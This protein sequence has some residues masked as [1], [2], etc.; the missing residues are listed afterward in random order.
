[1]FVHSFNYGKA[2]TN[3]LANPIDLDCGAGVQATEQ[4]WSGV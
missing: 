4:V 1:M 2:Q 3:I